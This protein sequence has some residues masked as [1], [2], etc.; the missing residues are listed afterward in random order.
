[1]VF[2][3]I[4]SNISD[5]KVVQT[6]FLFS[7]F[8][9]S[10]VIYRDISTYLFHVK[11]I[12]KVNTQSKFGTQV[13]PRRYSKNLTGIDLARFDCFCIFRSAD[14]TNITKNVSQSASRFLGK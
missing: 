3:V 10:L 4:I 6:S 5:D 12:V 8:Q 7:F 13:K 11:L 9:V 1:M 14:K 2:A